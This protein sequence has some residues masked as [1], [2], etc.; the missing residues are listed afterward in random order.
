MIMYIYYIEIYTVI[1]ICFFIYSLVFFMSAVVYRIKN[2]STLLYP[3]FNK[4]KC[5]PPAVLY[6]SFKG[7]YRFSL[8]NA[9]RQLFIYWL[10]FIILE[11]ATEKPSVKTQ[12]G[13]PPGVSTAQ[14]FIWA[15]DF[16]E[17]S[18]VSYLLSSVLKK[19]S[20]SRIISFYL[21]SIRTFMW[22]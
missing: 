19:L 15:A 13:V 22:L 17:N 20:V 4:Q 5:S 12:T 6:L 7:W 18:I 8:I 11:K 1:I 21:D 3:Y 14:V 16:K 9:E 2:S 10:F